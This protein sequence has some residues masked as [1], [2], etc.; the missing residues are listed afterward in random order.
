MATVTATRERPILMSGP[1]TSAT[2]SGRKTQTRRT[3]GLDWLNEHPYY[4][5][6][7]NKVRC[8]EGVWHFWEKGHGASAL[9]VFS[10]RCPYNVPGDRLWVRESAQVRSVGP[11]EGEFSLR[12]RADDLG[13]AGGIR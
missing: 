9:P 2:L 8:R 13:T 3:R 4:R 10:T 7:I 11:A 12:Y 5:D 1:M 6:R